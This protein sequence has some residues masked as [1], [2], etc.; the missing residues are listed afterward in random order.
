[1]A[2][3]KTRATQVRIRLG[4]PAIIAQAPPGIKHWGPYQ[5]PRVE[6]LA[7]GSLH[8][9]YHIEADSAKAYGL[10]PGHAVSADEGRS[11]QPLSG[12]PR[13]EGLLLPNGDRLLADS[14]KSKPAADL[15]LP[16]CVAG[17]HASYVDCDYY[18][19]KDLPAKL[20]KAWPFRRCAAGTTR[21]RREWATVDVGE[22]EDV[23]IVTEGVFVFPFFEQDRIRVA[24]DGSLRA[25]LYAL[26]HL[27]PRNRVLRPYLTRLVRSDDGGRSWRQLS[28]IPYQ[29]DLDADPH[30]DGRDGFTEPELH[31]LP[32]GS[33]FCLLR[34]TD[35]NGTG[36]MYWARSTDNCATWSRARVFDDCG[37][38]PQLL[39]LGCG[40]TL[41]SYGRPGL[42]VRATTD[43]AGLSWDRRVTVVAPGATYGDTCSYSDL[44]ALDARRALLVYSEFAVP[45]AAG[46]PCKTI[47]ARTLSV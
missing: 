42:Y 29:P 28:V 20:R 3:R 39:T 1:M 15:D 7:D 27:G 21:W 16:P 8:V 31:A 11:W 34:T 44:I 22:T 47:L 14:E 35:G 45:N 32:D 10:P 26:P 40:V 4:E 46:Q 19:A 13:A 38:W 23:R 37:V 5:F 17:V 25:T 43:P 18:R 36:P 41:A 2:Q 9:A 6:R 30:W 12:P 33:Q 24:P